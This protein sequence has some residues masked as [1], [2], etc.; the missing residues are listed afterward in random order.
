M[1]F[2]GGWRFSLLLLVVSEVQKKP[3]KAINDDGVDDLCAICRCSSVTL[4]CRGHDLSGLVEKFSTE[5]STRKTK[6]ASFAGSTGLNL[7]GWVSCRKLNNLD[8]LDLRNTEYDCE[9]VYQTVNHCKAT[10]VGIFL[11][12]IG[13]RVL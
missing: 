11:T 7:T 4:D 6:I 8:V 13:L 10:K 9:E 12:Y 1:N 3:V 2:H 5:K